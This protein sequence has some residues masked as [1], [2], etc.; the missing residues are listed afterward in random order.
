MLTEEEIAVLEFEKRQWKQLANK[1][2]LI[3]EELGLSETQYYLKLL[4][5]IEKEAAVAKYPALVKRLREV[6]ISQAW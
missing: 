3:K 2:F 4:G 6:A 1:E 5:I